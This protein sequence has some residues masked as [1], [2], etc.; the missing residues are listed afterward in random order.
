MYCQMRNQTQS[1][2]EVYLEFVTDTNKICRMK[3]E[4]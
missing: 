3:V 2:T 1:I 4:K